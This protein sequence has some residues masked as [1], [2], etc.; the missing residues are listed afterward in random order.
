MGGKKPLQQL[1][2]EALL[3]RPCNW[4]NGSALAEA[5]G[6]AGGHGGVPA[7]AVLA[8][9]A[10]AA[11]H[12]RA[13]PSGPSRVLDAPDLMDDYYL[14]L[15]SWGKNDVIAVALSQ[16]VYLWHA[17]DS[18]IDE[19]LTLGADSDYVSSVSWADHAA[20]TG[21]AGA[22]GIGQLLAVGTHGADAGGGGVQIW[23]AERMVKV[24]VACSLPLAT[25]SLPHS[26]SSK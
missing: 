12:H 18:R 24:R 15:L 23:D 11:A 22:G 17:A 9:S 21:G 8:S 5:S 10:G 19:L 20:T 1:G 25:L 6:L 2:D 26:S 3:L 16:S 4:T 13:L 14:N 7:S